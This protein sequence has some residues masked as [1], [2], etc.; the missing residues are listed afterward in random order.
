[1]AAARSLI[2]S[3]LMLLIVHGLYLMN[4]NNR[5]FRSWHLPAARRRLRPMIEAPVD[6]QDAQALQNIFL[7]LLNPQDPERSMIIVLAAALEELME[8]VLKVAV[9]SHLIP[10]SADGKIRTLHGL[11]LID[12]DMR[13]CLQ[14]VRQIRNHYAHEP[15]A[16]GLKDPDIATYTTH[17][18]GILE[19]VFKIK[20]D[21][22]D[23][24][25]TI[26][27]MVDKL[28]G[29]GNTWA[30]KISEEGE[31]IRSGFFYL[32]LQL[33]AIKPTAPP[34]RNP[35]PLGQFTIRISS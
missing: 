32:A 14:C 20:R 9:P 18:I 22:K 16:C 23:L 7:A 3:L 4:E 27:G 1:M 29:P 33:L 17:L 11:R 19:R 31:A 12:D 34:S 35:I 2:R 30:G 10:F 15:N 26:Q 21:V 24:N 25:S 5:L 6:P 8:E 28:S 13:D